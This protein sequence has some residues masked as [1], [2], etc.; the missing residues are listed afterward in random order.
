MNTFT[1]AA[2]LNRQHVIDLS[3]TNKADALNEL[4]D[5]IADAPQIGDLAVFR[6]AIAERE[7]IMSTGIGL[8][9]ALPHVKIPEVLGFISAIGRSK[10]GIEFDALDGKPVQLIVMI[11][12]P[13]SQHRHFLKVIAHVSKLLKNESLRQQLLEAPTPSELYDTLMEAEKTQLK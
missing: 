2:C 9:L 7:R 10:A 5:I 13:Q 3:A 1:L 12:A 11:A 8:G 4:V 6:E